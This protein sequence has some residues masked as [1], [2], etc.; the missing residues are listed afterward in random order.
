METSLKIFSWAAIVIGVLAIISGLNDTA[1][2]ALY[3]ALGGGMFLVQ[4]ILTLSYIKKYP[5][6]NKQT[7]LEERIKKLENK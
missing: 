1:D 3:A 2:D 6:M 7:E 4:G 5:P